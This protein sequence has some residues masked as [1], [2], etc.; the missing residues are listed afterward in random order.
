MVGAIQ[1]PQT[2]QDQRKLAIQINAGL[3]N[4]KRLLESVYRDAKHLVNLINT[5]LLQSSSLSIL[6]YLATQAQ[7]AYTSQLNPSTCQS[8]AGAIWIYAK[9][10]PLAIFEVKPY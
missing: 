8:T 4:V 2:T 10:D 6:D 3:D 5:Q 7:Y 1:S 9:C